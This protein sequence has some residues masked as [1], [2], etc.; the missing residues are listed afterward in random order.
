RNGYSCVPVALS[1]GLDIKLNTAVR[2]IRYGPHGVDI[3]TTNCRN[4]SN[5]VTYKGDAVLCTLPLGVLKQC[6]AANTQGVLNTVQFI[7]PLPD[8]KVAAIQRLGFGNLNKVVLCFERIFWD[9]NANLFGHVGSTTASRGE[10]FLFWNLY[11]APVL[12]ALVAGEAAAIMENVSDDVIVGRCIAV[13]KGIFGNSAVPQPKE[14]VVTR[15]RADPWSRGSYSFVAVGSSGSDYDILAVPVTPGQQQQ[16]GSP[17]SAPQPRLFFAEI[18]R[19]SKGIVP[20]SSFTAVLR[21]RT[22]DIV[23][24]TK[25][26]RGRSSSFVAVMKPVMLN[27]LN[28]LHDLH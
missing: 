3:A 26:R 2:Q 21:F 11:R 27:I 8:W 15:W 20:E 6:T 19:E 5:P 16:S 23:K 4:H 18:L 10:L 24:W 1:E 25:R 22:N 9:P 28:S 12:L 13:L 14:T 7:P 17:S